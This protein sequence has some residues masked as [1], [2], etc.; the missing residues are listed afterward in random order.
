MYENWCSFAHYSLSLSL[1]IGLAAGGS[2]T[3]S[4]VFIT[5]VILH[6]LI[7]ATYAADL[8]IKGV[9]HFVSDKIF[10]YTIVVDALGI[11]SWFFAILLLYREREKIFRCQSHGL[12]LAIFW[13]LNVVWFGLEIVSW[14][15]SK[16]WWHLQ[17]HVAIA[18]LVLYIVRCV[19]VGVI[20][21]LGILRPLCCHARRRGHT[22]LIN[23][24]GEGQEVDE[25]NRERQER[26]EGSFVKKR[27]TSAFAD[28]WKKAKL[29]FPYVWPKRKRTQLLY[30]LHMQPSPW[31]A[32]C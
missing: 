20:I 23:I 18:D 26:R 7:S 2:V 1:P 32:L 25:G 14:Q 28:L 22:L 5:Q 17:T 15:N 12:S 19:L 9:L 31:H 27:T 29:L 10:G 4:W 24:N 13:Q 8:I 21:S 3:H 30:Q 16:W 6:I 11:T